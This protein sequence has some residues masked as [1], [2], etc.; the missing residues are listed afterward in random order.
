ME[1]VLEV[2]ALGLSSPSCQRG[3]HL[4]AASQ[5]QQLRGVNGKLMIMTKSLLNCF[6]NLIVKCVNK[7]IMSPKKLRK[8]LG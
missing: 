3:P 4:N 6:S 7:K 5:I 1:M 2:V 8:T